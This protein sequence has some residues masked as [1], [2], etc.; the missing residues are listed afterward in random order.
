MRFLQKNASSKQKSNSE[1]TLV[2]L[3]K[4]QIQHLTAHNSHLSYRPDVDGL[5]AIAVLGVVLFHA[6]PKWLPGGFAGVDVFFVISGYLI[7]ALIIQDFGRG[8]FSIR[9]FYARRIRRIFPALLAILIVVWG[10]GYLLLMPG[11]LRALGQSLVHSAY[12]SNNFLLYGQA[13]YFD[14][15]AELKPLL[16]LW[17]LAVEE[18]F[19]IVWPWLLWLAIRLRPAG[20]WIPLGLAL[21]SLIA[22]ISATPEHPMATFFL[23]HYRGWELLTG[24]IVALHGRRIRQILAGRSIVVTNWLGLLGLGLILG[25]YLFINGTQPYPGWRALF[26][27]LGAAL[28][29]LGEPTSWFSRCGLAARPAV[30]I[31]L[32]SYPLYLWHWPLFSFAR[33]LYGEPSVA[34]LLGLI[35]AALLLAWATYRFLEKPVRRSG[36]VLMQTSWL[37]VA[38]LVILVAIGGLGDWTRSAKGFPGRVEGDAWQALLWSDSRILDSECQA[39]VHPQGTYCQR[40]SAAEPSHLLIG[41]SHANHFYPGLATLVG[42]SGGNLVQFEGPLRVGAD[43][44]WANLTWAIAHPEVRTVFV[45][46]HHGRIQQRDNPFAGTVEQM[47]DQLFKAG[48]QV[49]FLID[50]PEFDFDPRLCTERPP[51]AQALGAGNNAAQICSESLEFMRR[52]RP[53]YDRYI[54]A[55]ADSYPALQF[56]DTFSSLCDSGACSAIAGKTLLFRDRHHLTASGSEKAFSQ[57]DL[58][59]P[60]P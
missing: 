49:V 39:A 58:P 45:A 40:H 59:L 34:M 17:S 6:F 35:L 51:I 52:K 3:Q 32:I 8:D 13:G 57:L 5:R 53:D 41:D 27:V 23:P 29:I 46:Y 42:R 26:P 25:A 50:N 16:H 21:C 22:C 54:A 31:G 56:L 7:T 2:P 28:I 4:N 55:L 19:Y 38:G 24:A 10:L 15:D 18:Q 37:P 33:I 1:R 12:F 14:T 43:T 9:N 47:L 11:E 60:K 20:K 30:A 48:K 36:S 44:N